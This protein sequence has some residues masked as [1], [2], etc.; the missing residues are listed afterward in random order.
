MKYGVLAALLL[1]TTFLYAD[2]Q[3]SVSKDG[4]VVVSTVDDSVADN[5]V[6]TQEVVIEVPLAAAWSA[7]TTAEGW[8]SWAAPLAE[9]DFR[10]HGTIKTNYN[11]QG[12]IG[13]ATTNTLH[14]INFVP[15]RLLTLQA[16]VSVNWPDVL[17]ENADDLFNIIEFREEGSHRTRIIS[18]GVG[19]KD[20]EASR[21]LL[22]FFIPANE[23]LMAGLKHKLENP[24]Q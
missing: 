11:A 20:T 9:V 2:G 1:T 5:M 21:N 19:Y 18:H 23:K 17:K 12:E 16:D 8:E 24:K 6:L 10:I 13:D 22:D 15:N 3:R 7:Y 14:I 4:Q